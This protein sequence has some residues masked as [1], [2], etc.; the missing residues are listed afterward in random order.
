MLFS[1]LFRFEDEHD[2][3]DEEDGHGHAQQDAQQNLSDEPET[4]RFE[5]KQREV[6]DEHHE[7]RIAEKPKPAQ[8]TE[9]GF[10]DVFKLLVARNQLDDGRSAEGHQGGGAGVKSGSARKQVDRQTDGKAQ[11]QEL[12]FLSAERQQHNENQ[13]DIRMHIPS[14]TD[15]VD[16]QHLKEH[17]HDETDD[18]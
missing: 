14:K 16:D 6:V 8:L 13:I 12:P 10:G 4:E 9:V 18:L 17:E 5:Q 3:H 2:H 15:M 1:F 11:Y 7:Q